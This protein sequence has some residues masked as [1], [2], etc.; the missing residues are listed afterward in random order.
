MDKNHG[1]T[2]VELMV[3]MAIIC[4]LAAIVL[5]AF[6]NASKASEKG[7]KSYTITAI[8]NGESKQWYNVTKFRYSGDDYGLI[9]F[10]SEDGRDI[11]VS[12]PYS[13]EEQ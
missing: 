5:P 8:V 11:T 9:A 1:F 2:L 6:Q 12:K 4:M 3:I 13:V 7:K 10:T